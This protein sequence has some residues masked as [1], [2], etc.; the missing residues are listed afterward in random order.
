[1]P[2]TQGVHYVKFL[3]G[4]TTAWNNLLATPN[5]IDDDTLYFIYDQSNNPTEGTLYLGRKLI[6]GIGNGIGNININ[7]I[8]DIYIDDQTLADKQILTYN[9]TTNQWQN[10][11]LSTIISTAVSEFVGASANQDGMSGLVPGPRAGD[12]G[13][14]LRGDKT[15]ATITLPQFD[16]NAFQTIA[17]TN[18][19]TL[20]GLNQAA[21]GSILV[22]TQV[23]IE[24]T[25][26]SAGNISREII[27]AADLEDLIESGLGNET[28]IYMVPTSDPETPNNYD[29]Y[30]IINGEKELI[31]TIGNVDLSNYVQKSVFNTH[32]E[33]ID[34]IL[35]D[36]T[37]G[38]VTHKGL[39]SRVTALETGVG[40]LNNLLLSDGN[41]TL[42][43]EVNTINSRLQWHEIIQQP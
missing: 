18:T 27:T 22:K 19:I 25:S 40:N 30:M 16:P 41:T 24:W 23:G 35:N 12:E 28:I 29:E 10:V 26:M 11:S 39:I 3:R 32:V 6:S 4:S 7:D 1:M 20:A 36:T 5:A 37:S 33:N 2:T 9:D 43:E 15:W 31:G 13:K 21:V 38:G 8:G 17:N 14:F 42:V 34:Y